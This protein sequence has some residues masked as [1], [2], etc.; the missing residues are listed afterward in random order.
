MSG[1]CIQGHSRVF[2]DNHHTPP[3]DDAVHE[4]SACDAIP[5]VHFQL[6]YNLHMRLG[7]VAKMNDDSAL[8]CIP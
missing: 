3:G 5:D 4:H 7:T 2:I 8:L 6:Q 1:I